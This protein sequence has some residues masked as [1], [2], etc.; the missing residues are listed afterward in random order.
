VQQTSVSKDYLRWHEEYEKAS[1]DLKEI[2]KKQRG[3]RNKIE[4]LEN[5]LEQNLYLLGKEE[6]DDSY[7]KG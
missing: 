3:E 6:N 5:E 4:E 1:T 2:E 7:S